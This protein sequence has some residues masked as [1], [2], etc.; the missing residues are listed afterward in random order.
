MSSQIIDWTS[1]RLLIKPLIYIVGRL[2]LPKVS[3]IPGG[4]E[5]R[6][7]YNNAA[8]FELPKAPTT[9]PHQLH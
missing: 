9:A 4:V 3:L 2:I 7:F 5:D 8:S 6:D 1:Y